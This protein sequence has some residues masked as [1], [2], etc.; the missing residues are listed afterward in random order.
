[1]A[2]EPSGSSQ[3]MRRA[4]SSA[5]RTPWVSVAVGIARSLPESRP[6]ASRLERRAAQRTRCARR[7]LGAGPLVRD[8]LP[9]TG[10]RDRALQRENG[11]PKAPPD[12]RRPSV[13]MAVAAVTEQTAARFRR[14]ASS[15]S[16]STNR[17]RRDLMRPGRLRREGYH[18]TSSRRWLVGVFVVRARVGRVV[19]RPLRRTSAGSIRTRARAWS[20]STSPTRA[21]RCACSSRPTSTAS[22]STSTTSARRPDGSVT[23]TVFGT[24]DGARRRSTPP[25]SRSASRSRASARWRN[26]IEAR[27]PDVRKENRGGGR[28][29]GRRGH[30]AAHARGR[31][32]DPARR[33]LRELRGPLPLGRGEDAPG[34]GRPGDGAYTGPTLSLSWNGG[35]G[36]ADQLDA[37]AD[38]RERRSGHDPNT[39]IEHRELVRIGDVGTFHAAATEPHPHRVQHRR[40]DRGRRARRGSAAGSRRWPTSSSATSRRA[41]WIRPRSTSASTS[42]RPSSRTSRS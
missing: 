28:R 22:T 41:T 16:C 2:S 29:A 18:M 35:A 9:E 34:H 25:A 14:C 20:R 40:D 7:D 33:L 17:R 39:Y 27:Q 23:V 26:R 21:R 13:S 15:I 37:A 3:Y 42:S 5:R 1:M 36:H 24:D 6:H 10:P 11:K 31:A 38:E 19:R 30:H 32:R 12:R 8:R 4:S